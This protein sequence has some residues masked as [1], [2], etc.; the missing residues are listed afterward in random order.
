MPTGPESAQAA[1]ADCETRL[2]QAQKLEAVG[3]LAGSVA[4]D[5]NNILTTILSL[6]QL[7]RDATAESATRQD[8]EQIIAA[9][10]RAALQTRQL[11]V[12]TQHQVVEAVPEAAESATPAPAPLAHDLT[13]LLVEDDDQL[14][15]LANQ[16]LTAQ[17]YEV[18]AAREAG[19]ALKQLAAHPGPV[20][21]LLTDIVMPGVSGRQLAEHVRRLR[22]DIRVL[23]T[24]G[25]AGDAIMQRGIVESA[26]AFLA[27][28]YGADRLLRKVN[29]VLAA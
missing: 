10:E 1:L 21:L 13:V 24:A 5:L 3:Q 12:F 14:R 4:H 9:A 7:I 28:P 15:G 2:R 22:P 19:D 18:L 20:Q 16:I 6:A 27:K 29:E 8:A 11:L 23:F 26:S 17:G 25:Y